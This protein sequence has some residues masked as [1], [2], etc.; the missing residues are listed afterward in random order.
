M[1]DAIKNLKEKLKD[2]A[3]KGFW[4]NKNKLNCS[5]V[6]YH[7]GHLLK[8]VQE[9]QKSHPRGR[10]KDAPCP[11]ATGASEFL[12]KLLMG[13]DCYVHLCHLSALFD[14]FRSVGAANSGGI[15]YLQVMAACPVDSCAFPEMDELA[16]GNFVGIV[17]GIL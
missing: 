8:C 13:G 10:P 3:A 4:Y 12:G 1:S 15:S 11:L 7:A 5:H 14:K 6:H 2:C 9:L 17:M 16:W